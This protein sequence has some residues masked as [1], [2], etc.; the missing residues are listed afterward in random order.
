MHACSAWGIPSKYMH[1]NRLEFR[2]II[3]FVFLS[4]VY[5]AFGAPEGLYKLN[6]LISHFD[7]RFIYDPVKEQIILMNNNKNV[8]L[9]IG[10]PYVKIGEKFL[11][12]PELTLSVKGAVYIPTDGGVDIARYFSGKSPDYYSRNGTIYTDFGG[13]ETDIALVQLASLLEKGTSREEAETEVAEVEEIADSSVV[14][15]VYFEDDE[16]EELHINAIIIDAG[17]GGKDPGT[18]KNGIKEKDIVLRAALILEEKLKKKYPGKK[19]ILTRNK[20]V[21]VPLDDRA[22]IANSIYD[23]YGPTIF[24][25]IHT[26]AALAT[27]AYGFETWYIVNEYSRQVIEQG[28]VSSDKDVEEILNSMII[29]EL[30]IESRDLAERIQKNING[31]IGSVS[32]NR[33]I[34]ESTYIVIKKPKMPAV[35]VE[36][37]F[38]SNKSEAKRL[39][40]YSYLFK[41]TEG[42]LKGIDEFIKE[43]EST[44]GFTR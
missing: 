14:T 5:G 6:N 35:L 1:K 36:L 18:Y 32:R 41:I 2:L 16:P 40:N 34:K 43:Y 20:D 10:S 39:T 4:G 11:F 17:H 29:E 21:F 37:G 27:S 22:G 7:A 31:Q 3:F 30:Y 13:R 33:G 12:Y 15:P 28:E 24:I 38:I 9:F 44:K 19:I 23:K 26:N 25:S 8:V 42:I